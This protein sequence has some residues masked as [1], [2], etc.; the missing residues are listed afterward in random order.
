M[1]LTMEQMMEQMM[2]G[3]L[4]VI[5]TNQ[6]NKEADNEKSEVLQG[7]LVSR[8]DA[9]QAK[10]EANHEKC[11]ESQSRNNGRHVGCQSRDDGGLPRED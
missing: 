1:E 4:A 9:H 6:A 8:L 3:L 5:R 2:E 10:I 11:N 7:T